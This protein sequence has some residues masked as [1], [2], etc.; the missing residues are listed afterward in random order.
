MSVILAGINTSEVKEFWED[1]RAE[2]EMR[3]REVIEYLHPR[4]GFL[5]N[6]KKLIY[7]HL[8]VNNNVW[9]VLVQFAGERCAITGYD[10]P[11]GNQSWID[12]LPDHTMVIVLK[13]LKNNLNRSEILSGN[14]GIKNLFMH[15]ISNGI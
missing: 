1:V 6:F 14:P 8:S 15:K 9:I 13:D 3:G 4:A 5:Q 11:Y 2:F 12:E 10:N 7:Q